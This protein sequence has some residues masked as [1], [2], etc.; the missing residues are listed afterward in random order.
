MKMQNKEKIL[1]AIPD[2][3]NLIVCNFGV[4]KALEEHPEWFYDD[5]EIDTAYGAPANCIWNGSKVFEEGCVRPAVFKGGYSVYKGFGVNYC[6]TFTNFMLEWKHIF[7]VY[8]NAMAAAL[9]EVGGLVAISTET[10]EKHIRKNWPDLQVVWSTHTNYGRGYG[11][12][13][14]IAKINQLSEKELVVAPYTFNNKFEVLEKFAHPEN[15]GFIV[16][17][18]CIDDCPYRIQHTAMSNLVNLFQMDETYCILVRERGIDPKAVEHKHK[19]KRE[20]LQEYVARGFRHFILA[21]RGEQ[22]QNAFGSYL[23]YLVLPDCYR[24][25]TDFVNDFGMKEM[26]KR[27]AGGNKA[28]ERETE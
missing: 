17:D 12:D 19:I 22:I 25:F 6:L 20:N 21:G 9:N 5:F 27:D 7:D 8:G 23:E 14:E 26:A 16:N 2:A 18:P 28:S 1:F 4:L 15:V 11:L 13:T 10:L 24:P 3:V